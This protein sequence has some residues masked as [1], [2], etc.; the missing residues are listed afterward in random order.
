MDGDALVFV[1]PIF[2]SILEIL[3]IFRSG[4]EKFWQSAFAWFFLPFLASHGHIWTLQP[5]EHTPLSVE[6]PWHSI[7]HLAKV[8]FQCHVICLS[9]ILFSYSDL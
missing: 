7:T 6:C 8:R 5:T 1:L 3:I 4:L 2:K 9:F